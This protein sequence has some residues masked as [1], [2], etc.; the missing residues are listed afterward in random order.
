MDMVSMRLNGVGEELPADIP[1]SPFR[2]LHHLVLTPSGES[3][4]HSILSFARQ[5]FLDSGSPALAMLRG[6]RA[7][8]RR[9]RETTEQ[10]EHP[11]AGL[12]KHVC[13]TERGW[14]FPASHRCPEWL[15]N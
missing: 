12:P 5:Y 1:H 3:C 2:V 7:S 9:R 6:R 4:S 8:G 13:A 11:Y 15:W 14:L 10:G